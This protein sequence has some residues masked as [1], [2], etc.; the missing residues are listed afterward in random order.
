MTDVRFVAIASGFEVVLAREP[1][2]L[3]PEQREAVE[4]VWSAEGERLGAP[5]ADPQVLLHVRS[6][7][8]RLVGRLAPWS[9]CLAA[10]RAPEVF[11]GWA[12]LP[13][14]VSGLVTLAGRVLLGRRAARASAWPG[15]WELVPSGPL[16][17]RAAAHGRVD[18]V[19]QLLRELGEQ[20]PLPP[21]PRAAAHAFALAFDE[22]RGTCDVCVSLR[23]EPDAAA[24]ERLERSS[25]PRYEEF[26]V[27]RPVDVIEADL[28]SGEEQVPLSAALVRLPTP[29][30]RAAG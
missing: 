21:P 28:W 22:A 13:V 19:A 27:V 9:V 8:R 12:P 23:L 11:A 25:S 6:D 4:R 16:D 14:G 1:L 2:E 30:L 26:R 20:T 15:R 29:G 5:P 10:R 18:F 24:L 3:R 17:G 7:R